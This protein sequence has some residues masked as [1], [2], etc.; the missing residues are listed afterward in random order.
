DGADDG[1]SVR[2]GSELNDSFLNDYSLVAARYTVGTAVCAVGLIG[3]KRMNYAK[4]MS[5]VGT[6]A[7]SLS[8]GKA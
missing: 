6:V 2:I 3:P 8:T 7:N 4:M 5:L 1:I